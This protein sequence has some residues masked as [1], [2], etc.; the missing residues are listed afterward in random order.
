MVTIITC[1]ALV[2]AVST[3]QLQE[4]LHCVLFC[5]HNNDA[6]CETWPADLSPNWLLKFEDDMHLIDCLTD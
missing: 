3:Q 5:F 1:N 2:T 6:I 4:R